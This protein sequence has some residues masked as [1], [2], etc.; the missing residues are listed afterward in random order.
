L[1]TTVSAT[2]FPDAPHPA[3]TF[4]TPEGKV[5]RTT[6]VFETYWQF[7]FERQEIFFKRVRGL[8][9]PWTS[10][11]ILRNYRFTNVYRVSD[12]VSQHLIRHVI[13]EGDQSE[14][15]LFFRVLLFKLFNR[16]ETWELLQDSV[17]PIRW[18]TFDLDQYARVLD[19]ALRIGAR[20]YSAAYIIPCPPFDAERKHRNHLVLLHK[21]MKDQLPR[22]VAA[23]RSLES[24]FSLL[25]SYPS[26]GDFLA[27]QFAIDLNYSPL[28]SF[29]EME[30]VVAGPGARSGIRKAFQDASGMSDEEVIRAVTESSSK[31]FE[32]RGLAFRGLWGRPLQLIDCQSLF[33]EVDKY[34]RLAHPE[35]NGSSRKRIK[36]RF[37]PEARPIPQWYPP[38]WGV[39]VWGAPATGCAESS[40]Y[41]KDHS[42][43]WVPH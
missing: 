35:I 10:D 17:G 27:Y 15:E 4:C 5:L 36:Q 20:L 18:R 30:F 41:N 37:V 6:I 19:N 11:P 13:Y 25:R 16:I 31:E 29:S 21:M 26:I 33:C 28:T 34:S 1:T 39:H 40:A 22:K 9:P 14:E 3:E 42:T 2:L 43:A 7:A 12:R 23:A 32:R 8:L 24:V 38:K